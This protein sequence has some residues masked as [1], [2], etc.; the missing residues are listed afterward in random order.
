MW[1]H[2]YVTLLAK[3]IWVEVANLSSGIF[4]LTLMKEFNC[5]LL[6]DIKICNFVV[7]E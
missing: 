2:Q 5:R 1:Q 3:E 4:S 6:A 7:F